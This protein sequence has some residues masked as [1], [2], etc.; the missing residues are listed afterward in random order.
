MRA[1][2]GRDCCDSQREIRPG[3]FRNGR[4]LVPTAPGA[5]S[6]SGS[7]KNFWLLLLAS[8]PGTCPR[9]PDRPRQRLLT[10]AQHRIDAKRAPRC[11]ELAAGVDP[12]NYE[13]YWPLAACAASGSSLP[14]S[15]TPGRDRVL[16]R[17]LL[18]DPREKRANLC[19]P[20]PAVTAECPDRREL[21]S[22]C[23]AG[24]SF[25]VNPE[26]CGN[27]CRR[28]QRLRLWCTC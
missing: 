28:E 20:V 3:F 11:G 12:P 8:L 10:D 24:D 15:A 25:R 19:L 7:A 17:A 1:C 2:G 18:R 21:A 16:F 13:T 27:F 26:H 4:P 5:D 9:R 6:D 23:P 22:L 14:G